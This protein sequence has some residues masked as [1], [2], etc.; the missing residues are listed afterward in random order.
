[1]KTMLWA[2]TWAAT[3][4]TVS[5]RGRAAAG[6]RPR[7][8]RVVGH[9]FVTRSA[10]SILMESKKLDFPVSAGVVVVDDR[11]AAVGPGRAGH[12]RPPSQSRPPPR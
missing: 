1:M 6:P 5:V 12:A 2:I 4:G 9:V 7:H 10:A 11:G 8:R 3:M